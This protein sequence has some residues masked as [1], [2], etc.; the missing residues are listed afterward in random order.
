[1]SQVIFRGDKDSLSHVMDVESNMKIHLPIWDISVIV[2]QYISKFIFFS[3]F[4]DIVWKNPVRYK[5][6]GKTIPKYLVPF[7]YWHFS[8]SS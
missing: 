5:W 2:K 6:L 8:S 4:L 1:M 7:S 3:I